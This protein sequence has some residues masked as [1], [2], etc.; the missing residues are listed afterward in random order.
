LCPGAANIGFSITN[1]PVL[2]PIGS[3]FLTFDFLPAELGTIP[4]NRALLLRY[5][6]GSGT[7]VPL[8]T[9]VSGGF[10]T[11]RINHFSLFQVGQ[12]PATN[13]AETAR[14]FPNPYYTSRDGFVTIDNVPA[15][16]RVRIFTLRGAQVLDVKA[17]TAGLL[18]W[19]GTNGSGRSVA[20][21]V[22]LVMVESGA[23]KKVLKLAVI[24]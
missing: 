24:R 14:V 19:S 9:T 18:T 21:G 7:C 2:Q 1:A 15:L 12:V 6:P 11:A 13:T 20:S 23:T 17:N 4:T 8:E 5:D 10:M 16:A 22:Y 3:L